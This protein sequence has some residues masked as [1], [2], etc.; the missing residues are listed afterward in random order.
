MKQ[1]INMRYPVELLRRIDDFKEKNDF[2]TRTQAIIYLIQFSLKKLE[3]S[4]VK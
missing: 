3:K 2:T 1:F 4:D